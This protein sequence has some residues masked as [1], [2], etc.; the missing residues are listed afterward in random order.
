MPQLPI[1]LSGNVVSDPSWKQITKEHH[2]CK[3]RIAC[4]RGR[5]EAG[6][7]EQEGTWKNFDQ[8]FIDVDAWDLLGFNCLG[9]LKRGASVI[10]SGTLLTQEWTA[11][12]GSGPFSRIMVRANAVGLDLNRYKVVATPFGVQEYRAHLDAMNV[13]IPVGKTS[14]AVEGNQTNPAVDEENVNQDAAHV[15]SET[16]NLDQEAAQLKEERTDLVDSEPPF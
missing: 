8:L 6:E 16:E 11:K 9:T 7:G 15:E 10:V 2:V 1:T 13:P 14:E 5:F 3:F 12:D 4:S